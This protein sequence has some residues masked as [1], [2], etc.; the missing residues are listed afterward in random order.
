MKRFTA[1]AAAAGGV[2]GASVASV[3][4]AAAL[5]LAGC[6]GDAGG[7]EQA[8]R[9]GQDLTEQTPVIT[10]QP[11]SF[12]DDDIAFASHMVGHHQQAV[13]LAALVPGRSSDAEVLALARQIQAEQQPEIETLKAL[14]V[15]W[16]DGS[17]AQS[18][19]GDHGGTGMP[20]M[21][22]GATM[23]KLASLSGAE[24]DT[25]WL[26]TMI[27]H[28]RGAVGMADTE[29]ADGVNTDAKRLAQGIV[30]AQQAEIDRMNSML[31]AG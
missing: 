30:A 14:L 22:D 20:G 9:T 31:S 2:A 26:Q 11:A 23:A 29:I 13:E 5:L 8:G 18:G 27:D 16:N 25:L 24:F 28:H 17:G 21:A 7:D 6:S 15:Q 19:P 12:N 10:G 1:R 3:A 4:L